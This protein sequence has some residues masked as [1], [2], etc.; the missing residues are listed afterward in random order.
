MTFFFYNSVIQITDIY[1]FAGLHEGYTFK[2]KLPKKYNCA[3]SKLG[4]LGFGWSSVPWELWKSSSG[5][6]WLELVLLGGLLKSH[7]HS[8]MRFR[9][10]SSSA[11]MTKP[12]LAEGSGH[13]TLE[14]CCLQRKATSV[15][16]LE[17]EQTLCGDTSAKS[18]WEEQLVYLQEMALVPLLK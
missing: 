12:F 8:A 16:P 18:S 5:S 9:T 15:L 4:P 10:A 2:G 17:P 7:S 3:Q 11:S 13:L 1:T 14:R 6:F